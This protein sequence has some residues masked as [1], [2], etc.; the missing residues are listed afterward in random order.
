MSD[1]PLSIIVPTL[2][3][4]AVVEPTLASLQ[5]LRTLGVEVIVADGGST[6]GTPELS[7]PHCDRF[8]V[9]PRGRARQMNAGAAIATSPGLLFLHADTHLPPHALPIIEKALAGRYWGRFDVQ[10]DGRSRVLPLV[11]TLMN[12]R[13]RI[14]G[15]A[16]GDQAIFVRRQSF[17]AV[18]GFPDQPLME[19][20]E[21]S[22][23]MQRIGRPCCVRAR[24]RTSGR[25]WDREGVFRTI[26]L[27]WGLRL[28]YALG[29]EASALSRRYDADR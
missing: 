28:A 24:V 15:I 5:P 7:R 26:V 29:A 1:P 9:A 17:F 22:S 27:M 6:D 11:A 10:F 8:V 3:E 25:R 12:L 20:I 18:G 2:D 4:A 14:S 16:T 19:D 21:F 13:S 23:R